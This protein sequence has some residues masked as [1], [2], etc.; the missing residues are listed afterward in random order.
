M[1]RDELTIS[2]IS[3]WLDMVLNEPSKSITTPQRTSHLELGRAN[4][5]SML[6]LQMPTAFVYQPRKMKAMRNRSDGLEG[7]R[8][9]NLAT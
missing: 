4:C 7:C 5:D 3:R 1:G 6:S 8:L 9:P 2:P